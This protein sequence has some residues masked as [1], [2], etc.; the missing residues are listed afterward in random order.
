MQISMREK[1]DQYI[2]EYDTIIIYTL[3]G[4]SL[5]ERMFEQLL[6][7]L[8]KGVTEFCEKRFLLLCPTSIISK[9]EIFSLL[10]KKLENVNIVFLE[11]MDMESIL[12]LYYMYE[13]TDKIRLL[14]DNPQYPSLLNYVK[15]KVLTE[16]E[17]VECLLK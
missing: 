16:E 1:L 3:I 7:H 9:K 10:E 11:P 6:V 12:T 5:Y 15:Q 14:S 17:L 13:C 8:E 4:Q 2:K